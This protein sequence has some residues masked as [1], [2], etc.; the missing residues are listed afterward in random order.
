MSANQR[1]GYTRRSQSIRPV[2]RPFLLAI[3]SSEQFYVAANSS[4]FTALVAPGGFGI[5]ATKDAK[6]LQGKAR[7]AG[8]C[9]VLT[10]RMKVSDKA[11]LGARPQIR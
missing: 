7:T 4:S 6:N 3:D 1:V 10:I 5:S 2:H 8:D 11:S 9:F